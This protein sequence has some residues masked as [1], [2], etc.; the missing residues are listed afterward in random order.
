MPWVTYM[1]SGQFP[2]NLPLTKTM[3]QVLYD[4]R[5]VDMLVS[6][7]QHVELAF[8][9]LFTQEESQP[10]KTIMLICA[11]DVNTKRYHFP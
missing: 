5:E 1:A 2:A 11:A 8:H 7:V 9:M 6:S 4:I 3:L 10:C